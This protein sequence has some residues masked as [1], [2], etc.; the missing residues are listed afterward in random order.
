[1]TTPYS[2]LES[3]AFWKGHD[4]R[5]LY[6]PKFPIPSDLPIATAGS[7]FGQRI[8]GEL[9]RNGF[10]V[11]DVEPATLAALPVRYFD[12]RDNNWMQTPKFTGYL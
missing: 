6:R 8:A 1:M 9:R 5:D 4:W 12:G 10:A 3:R 7:C 2:G 11:M